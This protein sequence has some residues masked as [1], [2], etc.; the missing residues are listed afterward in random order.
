MEDV[1]TCFLEHVLSMPNPA[2]H[3]PTLS[4]QCCKVIE[5]C[6]LNM[7]NAFSISIH[8][9]NILYLVIHFTC[10]LYKW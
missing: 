8:F 2:V 3:I 9:G 7:L 10:I 5:I 1:V 4:E 6:I